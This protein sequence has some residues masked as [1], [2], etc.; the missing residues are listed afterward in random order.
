M[1]HTILLIILSAFALYLLIKKKD[2][3]LFL[4]A[5]LVTLLFLLIWE[6]IAYIADNQLALHYKFYIA[7]LAFNVILLNLH[8]KTDSNQ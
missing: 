4:R 8:K 2:F 5:F 3:K 6:G 1:L 7:L